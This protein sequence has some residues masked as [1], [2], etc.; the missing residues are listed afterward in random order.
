MLASHC[1]RISVAEYDPSATVRTR[2]RAIL[3]GQVNFRMDAQVVPCLE[4]F[5]ADIAQVRYRMLMS[6]LVASVGVPAQET[7]SAFVAFIAHVSVH[8][9]VFAQ[10]LARRSRIRAPDMR[11]FVRLAF[12]MHRVDVVLKMTGLRESLLTFHAFVLA[13]ALVGL[14]IM[15]PQF[16]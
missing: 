14:L 3:H 5:A 4:L 13:Q 2:V 9:G 16:T 7:C 15:T 11:T 8:L 6:V 10:R 1:M 12:E